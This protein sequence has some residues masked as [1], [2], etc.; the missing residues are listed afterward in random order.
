M[1]LLKLGLAPEVEQGV[2]VRILEDDTV[3][4]GWMGGKEAQPQQNCIKKTIFIIGNN[5]KVSGVNI[6]QS[7]PLCC[8]LLISGLN[9]FQANQI[10]SF[11][12]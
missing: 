6:C 1:T 8:R 7:Q 4:Q 2:R 3:P 12:S 10:K 9:C 11:S 5:V